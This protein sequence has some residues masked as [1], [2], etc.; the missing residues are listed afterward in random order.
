M[1]C[2]HADDY[3]L[4]SLILKWIIKSRHLEYQKDWT[5]FVQWYIYFKI[6]NYLFKEV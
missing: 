5:P 4:S 3:L 1:K 6:E 2:K